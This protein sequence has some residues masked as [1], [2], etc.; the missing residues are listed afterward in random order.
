MR[1]DL[2]VAGRTVAPVDPD[3]IVVGRLG[4]AREDAALV[5][6]RDRPGPGQVH[7]R[8]PIVVRGDDLTAQVRRRRF[9]LDLPVLDR[10]GAVGTEDT[11]GNL[12]SPVTVECMLTL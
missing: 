6:G 10:A 9:D 5:D 11:D 7:G 4:I 8:T 1:D 3:P 12:E 2:A